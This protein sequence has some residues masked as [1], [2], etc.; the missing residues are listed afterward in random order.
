MV[1]WHNKGPAQSVRD[2]LRDFEKK[3]RK[4]KDAKQRPAQVI[5]LTRKVIDELSEVERELR[6]AAEEY[7]HKPYLD[8]RF[9]AMIDGLVQDEIEKAKKLEEDLRAIVGV[10]ITEAD[11]QSYVSI[12]VTEGIALIQREKQNERKV[13]EMERETIRER[14]E[15]ASDNVPPNRTKDGVPWRNICYVARQLGAIIE[16][17]THHQALIKFPRIREAPGFSPM[18]IPVSKDFNSRGIATEMCQQLHFCLPNYK[19]PSSDELHDA[20]KAGDLLRLA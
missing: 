12:L 7:K 10:T 2:T 15:R 1:F 11:V 20:L 9:D 13:E 16:V 4:F 5:Q 6:A 8:E 17:R 14:L 19:I 18:S 3:V